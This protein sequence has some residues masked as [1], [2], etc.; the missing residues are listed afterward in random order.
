MIARRLRSLG[1]L[2]LNERNAGFLGRYNAPAQLVSVDDKVIAKTLATRTGITVPRTF[3]VI[4]RFGDVARLSELLPSSPDFVLKPVRGAMGNGVLVIRERV[5]NDF[6]L[7]NGR[8]LSLNDLKHH[9]ANTLAGMHSL[10]GRPDRVLVEERLRVHPAYREIAVEGVPDVRIIVFRGVPVMAMLR[11][12]TSRSAGRANLHH[13][14]VA[15]G[16][17]IA[18]GRTTRAMLGS[19]PIAQHPDTGATLEG[20]LVPDWEKLLSTAALAGEA[21]GLGYLGLDLVHDE[22]LGTVFLEANARPGLGIQLANG[23]GLEPRLRAVEKLA[24]EGVS[25]IERAE[26]ARRLFGRADDSA[27]IASSPVVSSS[28]PEPAPISFFKR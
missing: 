22:R 18:T 4:E 20:R 13:G 12:P 10:G 14:A 8:R 21:F 19:R 9:V 2:G 6:L 26:L 25:A 24:L 16:V 15:V 5:D 7:A 17:D 28:S 11:L 23:A 1:L 27:Q 3:S